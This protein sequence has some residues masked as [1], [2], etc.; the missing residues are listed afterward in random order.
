M[1]EEPKIPN[2]SVAPWRCTRCGSLNSISAFFCSGCGH[3][4]PP[5]GPRRPPAPE[6][7][8]GLD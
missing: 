1:S 3:F 6:G 4:T 7:E 8:H 5:K 2:R